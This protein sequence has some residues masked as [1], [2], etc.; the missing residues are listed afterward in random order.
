MSGNLILGNLE[1]FFVK[2][3]AQCGNCIRILSAKSLVCADNLLFQSHF[4]MQNHAK[5]R[6]FSVPPKILVGF[7][8]KF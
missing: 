6:A 4:A 3:T 2:K 8:T 5:F 7:V 1:Q